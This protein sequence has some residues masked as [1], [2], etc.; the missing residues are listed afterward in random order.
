MTAWSGSLTL[1]GA[2]ALTF[3]PVPVS[4]TFWQETLV[5]PTSGWGGRAWRGLF[6]PNIA[7][8]NGVR[9]RVTIVSGT[10]TG[11]KADHASIGILG[12]A[13]A[14]SMALTDHAGNTQPVELLFGG[15][16]GFNLPPNS[17][18]TSDWAVLVFMIGDEFIIDI[19]INSSNANYDTLARGPG[20]GSA[21]SWHH[22][23][24]ADYNNATVSGYVGNNVAAVFMTEMDVGAVIGGFQVGASAPA[25]LP[26]K[27]GE[28]VNMSA[29]QGVSAVL[30]GRGGEIVK[31]F[32]GTLLLGLGGMIAQA[33]VGNRAQIVLPGTAPVSVATAQ[34]T[35][36]HVTIPGVGVQTVQPSLGRPA[37]AAFF[38]ATRFDAAGVYLG[39]ANF[40]GI[41]GMFAQVDY[42]LPALNGLALYENQQL[43]YFTPDDILTTQQIY[44][45]L[46]GPAPKNPMMTFERPDGS[47][48]SSPVY[49]GG[50]TGLNAKGRFSPGTYLV[51]NVVSSYF[52]YPGVWRAFGPTDGVGASFYV[53]GNPLAPVSVTIPPF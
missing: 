37:S 44:L 9:I 30:A 11:L 16:S 12:S 41:G 35:M 50:L 34:K 28:I 47:T 53:S 38:G 15:L 1:N 48:F 19:D 49:V 18:I 40:S 31:P 3:G 14:P 21:I 10:T 46:A 52:T 6:D 33:Q 4:T 25:V 29:F 26:G 42:L 7:P 27:G 32:T 23:M 2:G 17:S 13:T 39:N 24:A 43:E 5:T 36:V 20:D 8:E 22:P 51:Y 45:L